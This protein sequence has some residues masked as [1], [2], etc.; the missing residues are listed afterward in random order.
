MKFNSKAS[1]PQV[2]K[3]HEGALAYQLDARMALYTLA[4]TSSLEKTFYEGQTDRMERLQ[5]LIGKVAAEDPAFVAKLAI[6]TREQMYL[7]SVPLVLVVELARVHQGDDLVRRTLSRV[8]RRA[9]EITELLA[10]YQQANQ[11]K[12]RKRLHRLSKQ[13]QKGIADAFNRFDA[14]QFAKY[15]RASAVRLRDA[16]FL[17]HP[18]AKDAA[19]QAIFDRI[20]SGT[21]E[22]PQ[23]WEVALSRAGQAETQDE[24]EGLAH[25]RAAWEAM[26]RGGKMGYMAQLR[27]LRNLLESQVADDVLDRVAQTMSDPVEVARSQQLPFRFLSAYREL[28]GISHPKTGLLLEALEQAMAASAANIQGFSPETRVMIA[29]DVSGSMATA[30][31]ARSRVQYMDVGLVLSVLLRQVCEQVVTGVFGTTYETVQ[32]APRGILA[33]VEKLRRINVGYA[34]NGYLVLEH[35]IQRK[36]VM[37]KVM[38]F[39]DMQLWNSHQG[40]ESLAKLWPVYKQLAPAAK[41]YVFDLAGY[42]QAPIDIRQGDVHLLAGWSDKIFDLLAQI[43]RGGNALQLIDAIEI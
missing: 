41:L 25:K 31:S 5:A 27:N 11:R 20:A 29:T 19:Q 30:L 21:L 34:T 10:Y 23:T 3:N 43:E 12:G 40:Q 4:V 15:D 35:L 9:D 33:S 1:H 32:M 6:Y 8:I 7:R 37:D 17:S 16:L 39:T 2:T 22:A 38:I 36:L 13:V 18:V 24:A 14:Y 26:V 42:G 28:E